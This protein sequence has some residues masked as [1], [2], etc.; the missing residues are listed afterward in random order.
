LV[1]PS[2]QNSYGQGPN[3][4]FFYWVDGTTDDGG[5]DESWGPPLD[6]GLAFTQWNSY[7]VN[8][9]PL[10]WVSHPDNVKNMYETG[11]TTNNNVSLS[12]A[13]EKLGYRLSMGYSNQTGIIP[14][15]DMKKY[16][17]SGNCKLQPNR[18]V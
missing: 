14:N 1:I 11:V 16:T 5:V 7:T 8:G 17:I 9:A 4:D 3:K 18:K 15:T 13:T 6:R 12:G 2:F 10:P